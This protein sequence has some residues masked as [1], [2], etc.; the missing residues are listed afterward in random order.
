MRIVLCRSHQVH[1]PSL[2]SGQWPNGTGESPV[3]PTPTSEF[4]LNGC[5]V[6]YSASERA[7]PTGELRRARARVWPVRIGVDINR[8]RRRL[9]AV[10]QRHVLVDET[11]FVFATAVQTRDPLGVRVVE[12]G[13][14][15]CFVHAC[16]LLRRAPRC[17]TEIVRRAPS[18]AFAR[19]PAAKFPSRNPV[20]TRQ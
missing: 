4:G 20:F 2:P 10:I 6:P 8:P 17:Q 5:N 1:A 15:H 18:V 3:P 14:L 11:R 9:G 13:F 16:N 12:D 7:F 19:N